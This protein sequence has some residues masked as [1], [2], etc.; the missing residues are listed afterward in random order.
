MKLFY[1]NFR[2]L[3]ICFLYSKIYFFTVFLVFFI[4]FN[5]KFFIQSH[6][7]HQII[8]V[9]KLYQSMQAFSYNILFFQILFLFDLLQIK[10]INL[11]FQV[12]VYLIYLWHFYLFIIY[13]VLFI[14]I[15]LINYCLFLYLIIFLFL[16]LFEFHLNFIFSK[17]FN[18][19]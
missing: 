6:Q 17:I 19:S 10:L 7:D 4:I 16:L 11:I 8:S 18:L 15:Q 9:Q 2:L 3:Q 5:F 13:F 14:T 1:L 12:I